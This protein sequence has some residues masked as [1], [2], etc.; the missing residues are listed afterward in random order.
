MAGGTNFEGIEHARLKSMVINSDPT[1]VTSRGNQ[2]KAASR[3]LDDLSRALAAHLG[4]IQWEGPAAESFKTWATDLNRSA[5][6]ISEYSKGAGDAMVQAGEALSTAKTGVPEP[7]KTDIDTVDRHSKQPCLKPST[8]SVAGIGNPSVMTDAIMKKEDP[9]WVSYAEAAAAHKR[10]EAAHQ[11][12]IHQMEKLGQAYEAATT[13]LNGLKLPELPGESSHGARNSEENVTIGGGAYVGSGGSTGGSRSGGGY[14]GGSHSPAGTGYVAGG[15]SMASH[16]SASASQGAGPLGHVPPSSSPGGSAPLP[17]YPSESGA[18]PS[19][20]YPTDRPGTGLDGLPP[21]PTPTGSAGPGHGGSVSSHGQG[22]VPGYPTTPGND[23][24]LHP[25]GGPAPFGGTGP[26]GGAVAP[27][28][29]G[30]GSVP[31]NRAGTF[32]GG[33]LPAGNS[34]SGPSGSGPLFGTREAQGRAG[35]AGG[36]GGGVQPGMGGFGGGSVVGGGSRGRGSGSTGGGVIGEQSGPVAGGEFTPGGSGLRNRAPG[37]G[38][39]AEGGARQ[40]Q[41]GMMGPGMMG[42]TAERSGRDRRKRADYLHED[43]ETW[44]SGTPRSN[45]GVIE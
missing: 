21:A 2:L 26:F 27:V 12:A 35:T 9:T 38:A 24:V 37:I 10:V 29:G 41:N 32:G 31:P 14:R 45:P 7:P 20:W 39:A 23:P 34:G 22:G 44:T 19:P 18:S 43:E 6:M 4:Q 1:K 5:A 16:P 28:K 30:G 11:E 42:G 8:V 13:K 33:N 3:V 17:R 15:G 25:V 40:V 36:Q